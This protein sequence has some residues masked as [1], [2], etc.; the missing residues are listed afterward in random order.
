MGSVWVGSPSSRDGPWTA[1]GSVG[2]PWCRKEGCGASGLPGTA[3]WLNA[4]GLGVVAERLEG[5]SASL[6]KVA[7][8]DQAGLALAS[9]NDIRGVNRGLSIAIY[10]YARS[11]PGIQVGLINYVRDNPDGLRLLP[12]FNH[13]FR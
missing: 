12:L 1:S 3:R 13:S 5:V 11:S 9:Y 2:W 10:N 8:P 6:G 4:G 7:T